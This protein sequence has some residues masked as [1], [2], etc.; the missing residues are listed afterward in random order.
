MPIFASLFHALLIV[1]AMPVA[2]GTCTAILEAVLRIP[3]L[4]PASRESARGHLACFV[5]SVA[6][7]TGAFCFLFALYEEWWGRPWI[8]LPFLCLLTTGFTIS[9]RFEELQQRGTAVSSMWPSGSLTGLMLG[10]ILF[11]QRYLQNDSETVQSN[12]AR[13]SESSVRMDELYVPLPDYRD[14]LIPA[15][16]LE[17]AISSQRSKSQ[18]DTY[19]E[20]AE[21]EYRQRE[22]DHF[23]S[24]TPS[25]IYSAAPPSIYD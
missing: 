7:A 14:L 23:N 9:G 13:A 4:A 20:Q 12:P 10:L 3:L 1:L 24:G 25:S 16:P 5:G 11:G 17:S 22:V 18:V 21:R 19:D 2:A 6:G 8:V 15:A